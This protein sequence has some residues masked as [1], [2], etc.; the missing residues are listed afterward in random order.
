MSDSAYKYKTKATT[1]FKKHIKLLK[2]RNAENAQKVK[3]TVELLAKGEKLP[4]RFRDHELK[5][6]CK[7]N[8]ECHVLPDLLLIYKICENVLILTLVD[9]GT[10]SDLFGK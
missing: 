9:T 2:K 5:G 10:H 7:G 6:D 4:E 1:A 3:D 8:R